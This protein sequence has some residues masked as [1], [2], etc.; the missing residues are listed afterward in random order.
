MLINTC[1]GYPRRPNGSNIFHFDNVGGVEVILGCGSWQGSG[2]SSVI[3]VGE[4]AILV[5]DLGRGI[6]LCLVKAHSLPLKKM[7]LPN[8][9]MKAIILEATTWFFPRD[10]VSA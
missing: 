7:V 9:L 5:V 4:R 1:A 8:A 6:N 3:L 10:Q 2:V